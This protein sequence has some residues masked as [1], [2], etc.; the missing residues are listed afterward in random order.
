MMRMESRE[1]RESRSY[2]VRLAWGYGLAWCIVL[3]FVS[4]ALS[5]C[6]TV[7]IVEPEPF[8]V[9]VVYEDA[10]GNATTD[11]PDVWLSVG[12]C[13]SSLPRYLAPDVVSLGCAL[14]DHD[15]PR[16]EAK[17]KDR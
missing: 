4:W 8:G 15:D 12:D 7:P 3:A 6:T 14:V 16:A 1:Y 11:V 2:R 13:L 10:D 9:V 17:R 5:G